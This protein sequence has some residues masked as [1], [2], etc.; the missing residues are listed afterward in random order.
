MKGFVR[1]IREAPKLSLVFEDVRLIDPS[2]NRDERADVVVIDGVIK[3]ILSPLSYRASSEASIPVLS[4]SGYWLVPGLVDMHVHLREPG[5]EYKETIASGTRAAVAGGFVAVACMPNTKPPNDSHAVTRF[6]IEKSQK[7]GSCMVY[8]VAAITKNLAGEELTEMGTIIE[9]GAVAFSDDG[10]PVMNAQ[11]MRRAMEY[12]LIFSVPIISHCE[13]LHLS[14]DGV[15]NEGAVS[16]RLGLR[17]IPCI[18]EEVMVSRDI[19][20]A[21]WT[22]AK[23]HIAHVSTRGSVELVRRAKKEGIPVTAE[24]A[25]HYFSLTDESIQTYDPVYKVNPPLR[26]QEDVEAIIEGLSDGTIDAIATDHAPHSVLEKDVEF[27]RASFGMI[28]L[29]TALPLTL[30]LVKQ[31]FISPIRAIALLSTNPSKILGIPYGSIT[32]GKPAS[33]TLIN[34]EHEWI[35]NVDEFFSLSR[36]CPFNGWKVSG[37]AEL[38]VVEGFPVFIRTDGICGGIEGLL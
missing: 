31:G 37:I 7:E 21:K 36:N 18:A 24:T 30:R 38:T 26:T 23:L 28:G 12:S 9:A 5:E 27:D 22:G 17:G 10:R 32:V 15:M 16:L 4:C 6:I 1:P 25:P 11:I 8:P 2:S 34:P 13:D 3:E 29:E 14:A 20:I 33:I 35:V 19:M